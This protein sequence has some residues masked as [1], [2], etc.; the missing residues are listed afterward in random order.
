MHK[1][2]RNVCYCL[3]RRGKCIVMHLSRQLDQLAMHQTGKA[4]YRD[5]LDENLTTNSSKN[6]WHSLMAKTNYMPS[7]KNTTSADTT[8]PNKWNDFC[9]RF[10]KL[11][12]IYSFLCHNASL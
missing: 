6:I 12:I 11:N 3:D 2:Q 8:L 9:S 10:D 7:P 5:R 4:N 1:S